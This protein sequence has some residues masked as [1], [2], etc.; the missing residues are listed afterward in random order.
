MSGPSKHMNMDGRNPPAC[1]QVSACKLAVT[2]GPRPT[3][4]PH[5]E[6][7][8]D[9]CRVPV[10][11]PREFPECDIFPFYHMAGRQP[12]VGWPG[13]ILLRDISVPWRL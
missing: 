4:R 3:S 9:D 10:G 12:K 13:A 11:D 1:T 6:R 2:N 5:Y 8:V 7:A